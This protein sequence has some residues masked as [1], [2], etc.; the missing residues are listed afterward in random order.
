[1][2]KVTRRFFLKIAIAIAAIVAFGQYF[3]RK[4]TEPRAGGIIETQAK[5]V[6]GI[7]VVSDVDAHSQC[8]LR[9]GINC[10]VR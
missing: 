10:C 9:V 8:R 7:P 1:M 6:R 5:E 2:A 4:Y 3:L